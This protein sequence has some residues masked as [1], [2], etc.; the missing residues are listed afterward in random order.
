MTHP[1]PI[2]SKLAG[3]YPRESS[4]K[5]EKYFC[6]PEWFAFTL[7]QDKPRAFDMGLVFIAVLLIGERSNKEAD[8]RNS[9]R[10]STTINSPMRPGAANAGTNTSGAGGLYPIEAWDLIVL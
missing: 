2:D 7:G 9:T 1:R 4:Q 5:N 6:F 3:A 8:R 10:S